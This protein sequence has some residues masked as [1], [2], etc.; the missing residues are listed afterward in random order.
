MQ[1]IFCFRYSQEREILKTVFPS[2]CLWERGMLLCFL[3]HCSSIT[4][5]LCSSWDS[6]AD[7]LMRGGLFCCEELRAGVC[8]LAERKMGQSAFLTFVNGCSAWAELVLPLHR[9]ELRNSRLLTSL[10]KL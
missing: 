3:W 10:P 9:E 5:R 1:G 7:L 2:L 6:Q 4:E 8:L